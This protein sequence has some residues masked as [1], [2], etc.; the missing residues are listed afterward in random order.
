[1]HVMRINTYYIYLH[2]IGHQVVCGPILTHE[3]QKPMHALR[4]VVRF[5]AA[6]AGA[7]I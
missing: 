7:L 1:M 2:A 6:G 4:T 3:Y 5:R